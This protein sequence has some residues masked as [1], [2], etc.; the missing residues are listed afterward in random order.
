MPCDC[1]LGQSR[2]GIFGGYPPACVHQLYSY[3]PSMRDARIFHQTPYYL[4]AAETLPVG[5]K[6]ERGSR[7][8]DRHLK[9]NGSTAQTLN[10]IPE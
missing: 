7:Q 4:H 5:Y 6:A 9:W 3:I 8:P 1:R 10:Y 2:E